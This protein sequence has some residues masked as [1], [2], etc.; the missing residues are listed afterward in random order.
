MGNRRSTGLVAAAALAGALVAGCSGGGTGTTE[1]SPAP[2]PIIPATTSPQTSA[3]ADP[4]P[5]AD[6]PTYHR[7]NGRSGFAANLAPVGSLRQAWQANLDGAV[8]GQPLVVGD[9]IL[10]ATENDTVYALDA[11]SGAVRWHTHVGTPQPQSGLPCGDIDPLGITSTMAYDQATGRVF[12]LAETVGGSHV[13][14]GFDV[15]T[16]AVRVRVEVEPPKGDKLAHQQRS[17]LTVLNGRVYVAYG[18][19]DG[20]CAQYIGSVV[21]VT[22]NGTDPLGY[23]IP[24]TREAGI[25]APG[26]AVVSRGTLLYSVGNGESTSGYDGSDSVIALAPDTLRR[27]DLFAPATWPDDNANDLDLG[28][29]SP[30]VIGPWVFVAGKRGTGYVMHADHLGGVGGQVGEADVC[31]SFGGAAVEGATAYLPCTDGP[32][33]LTISASGRPVV[34]WHSAVSAN[35]APTV[36]GGAVWVADYDAG[37]LYALDQHTGRVKARVDVGELPHFASPTLSGSTVYLGT[38]HGVVAVAG[39]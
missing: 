27:V 1:S 22:T 35:G 11:A 12:A 23:A 16:G 7:D 15:L 17:A 31:R 4:G 26:G 6:W 25:W 3:T 19:L 8:Y 34:G 38:L 5:D 2:P 30:V 13:L 36:G 10:A 33:S 39:A 28:S 9:M 37:T 20:D 18:G 32:R 24:T 21:S 14:Y 29:S